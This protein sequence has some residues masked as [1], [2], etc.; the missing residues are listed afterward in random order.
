MRALLAQEIDMEEL[1]EESISDDEEFV[2][3]R[4]LIKY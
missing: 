1:F 2:T 4:N 3:K